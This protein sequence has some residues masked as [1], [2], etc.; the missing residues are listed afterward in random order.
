MPA[1]LSM[2]C[3]SWTG[4]SANGS[5]AIGYAAVFGRWLA[6]SDAIQLANG[7]ISSTIG[8]LTSKTL[9]ACWFAGAVNTLGAP[10]APSMNAQSVPG[11]DG[12]CRGREQRGERTEGQVHMVGRDQGRVV[13]DN[14]AWVAP[15]VQVL[16]LDLAPEQAA[17]GV[18]VVHPELVAAQECLAVRGEVARQRQRGT[19]QDWLLRRCGPVCRAT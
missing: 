19:D 12:R 2:D 1:L 15:V 7:T 4:G 14:L 17:R 16:E 3:V 13:G 8:R 10:P 5:F 6:G 18:H 11:R 9:C